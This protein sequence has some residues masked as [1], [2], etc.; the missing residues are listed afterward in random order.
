MAISRPEIL[1]S[2]LRQVQLYVEDT[3]GGDLSASAM[4]RFAIFLSR[5][6]RFMHDCPQTLEV[7]SLCKTIALVLAATQEDVS[8]RLV[9]LGR[10][11]Y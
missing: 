9:C 4:E 10:S 3:H 7:D 11:Y 2:I 5:F 6:G 1:S 8:V